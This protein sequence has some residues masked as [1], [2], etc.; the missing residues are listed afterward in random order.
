MKTVL[1]LSAFGIVAYLVANRLVLS[2]VD[3][4]CK[5]ISHDIG[6]NL[7][8]VPVIMVVFLA[9]ACLKTAFGRH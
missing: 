4:M 5:W 6:M 3:S 1:V 9:F 2:I 8:Y 7:I